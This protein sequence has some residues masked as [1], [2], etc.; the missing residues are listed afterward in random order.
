MLSYTYKHHW[1]IQTIMS[2]PNETN[3]LH[4]KTRA[5][6]QLIFPIPDYW[7]TAL[8]PQHKYIAATSEN[9]SG[10]MNKEQRELRSP[11]MIHG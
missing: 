1:Q 7:E 9:A 5:S 10:L 8:E 6:D 4:R 3:S 11:A 2:K